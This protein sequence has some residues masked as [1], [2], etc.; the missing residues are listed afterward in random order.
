[1]ISGLATKWESFVTTFLSESADT[2]TI[3]YKTEHS[4]T[5]D[6]YDSF[7]NESMDSSDPSTI[8]GTTATTPDSVELTGKTHLDLYGYSLS[9]SDQVENIGIGLFQNADALFTCLLSSALISDGTNRTVFDNAD[10]VHV[11]KDNYNYEVVG[12]KRRG[13]GDAFLLDVFLKKTNE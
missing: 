8:S 12:I 4:G 10:Y 9:T 2:V 1:M 13:L 7:F 11:D 3:Y 5:S 6:S